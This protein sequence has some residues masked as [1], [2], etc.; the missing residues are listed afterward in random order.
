MSWV[1]AAGFWFDD[2]TRWWVGLGSEATQHSAG[3]LTASS[4]RH[5]VLLPQVQELCGGHGC[6]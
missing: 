5:C 2:A 1:P 6:Y 3:G 4:S